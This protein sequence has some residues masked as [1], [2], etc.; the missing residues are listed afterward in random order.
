MVDELL[1]ER[2]IGHLGR[3]GQDEVA[4]FN[5]EF[6]GEGGDDVVVLCLLLR[7]SARGELR[8]HLGEPDLWISRPEG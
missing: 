2:V 5:G 6:E 4:N 7:D 1:F 8:F 3:R